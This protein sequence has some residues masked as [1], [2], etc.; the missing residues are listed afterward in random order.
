MTCRVTANHFK[1]IFREQAE[2]DGMFRQESFILT[3]CM[4]YNKLI[5]PSGEI[6]KETNLLKQWILEKFG[7]ECLTEKEK[8]SSYNLSEQIVIADLFEALEKRTGVSLKESVLKRF[9]NIEKSKKFNELDLAKV[10]WE[11]IVEFESTNFELVID[12]FKPIKSSVKGLKLSSLAT[13]EA[14]REQAFS[15]KK[16]PIE[17]LQLLFKARKAFFSFCRNAFVPKTFFD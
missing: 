15:R 5:E 13:G 3:A 16:S 12:D 9:S 10:E 14:L 7:E 8:K 2:H 6:W 4:F 17:K 1:Q 11:D